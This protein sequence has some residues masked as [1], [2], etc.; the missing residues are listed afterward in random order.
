MHRG[1]ALLPQDCIANQV[2]ELMTC[3]P[4]IL[5]MTQDN[6]I[7]FLFPHMTNGRD[8]SLFVIISAVSCPSFLEALVLPSN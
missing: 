8:K 1:Q 7:R 4:E 2:G 6:K 3:R 5:A